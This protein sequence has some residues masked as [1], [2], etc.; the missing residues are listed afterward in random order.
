MPENMVEIILTVISVLL[1]G[2]VIPWLRAQAAKARASR[3]ELMR[4]GDVAELELKDGLL[5]QLKGLVYSFVANAAEKEYPRIAERLIGDPTFTREEVKEELLSLGKQVRDKVVLVFADQS[6]AILDVF[7]ET[8][9]SELI[10]R[11]VDEISP[12]NGQ[13]TSAIFLKPGIPS[14]LLDEGVS[15]DFDYEEELVIE[16]T[17]EENDEEEPEPFGTN[18]DD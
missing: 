4:T 18:T 2:F 14:K 8:L 15:G 3:R 11:A 5:D 9:I 13:E 12:F 7:G 17:L 16:A 1:T 10:R 6:T